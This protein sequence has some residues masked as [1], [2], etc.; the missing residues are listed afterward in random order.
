MYRL[1]ILTCRTFSVVPLVVE[2]EGD[3]LGILLDRGTL[4]ASRGLVGSR[5]PGLSSGTACLML[6]E[7]AY[8]TE[9]V[10]HEVAGR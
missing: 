3:H 4:G 10:S 2:S 6:G 9:F 7:S 8:P 1:G 5:S